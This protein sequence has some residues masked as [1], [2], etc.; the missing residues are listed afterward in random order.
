[1]S[2]PREQ[3]A[4]HDKLARIA[5][6]LGRVNAADAAT[7]AVIDKIEALKFQA[8]AGGPESDAAADEALAILGQVVERYESVDR[9]NQRLARGPITVEEWH[10]Q[11]ARGR[12]KIVRR[13]DDGTEEVELLDQMQWTQHLADKAQRE[14]AFEA[15]LRGIKIAKV[16]EQYRDLLDDPDKILAMIRDSE[17][18]VEE[19]QQ[20]LRTLRPALTNAVYQKVSELAWSPA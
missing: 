9:E 13:Y 15:E 2:T 5:F 10:H 16:P 11:D 7:D 14:E 3:I 8:L 12:R 6:L 4:A 18:S 17:M 20:L 1:M 19:R